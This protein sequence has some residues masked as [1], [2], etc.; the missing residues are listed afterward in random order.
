MPSSHISN[1]QEKK[2]Y[3][4][5]LKGEEGKTISITIN[6]V[7]K[8]FTINSI[9]PV[10]EGL[11]T[12]P[13]LELMLNNNP[14]DIAVIDIGGHNFNLRLF[15]NSGYSLDERG[16]S[17]EQVGINTL[18][19]NLHSELLSNLKDRDRKINRT[20]LR[21][22]VKNRDLY[23]DMELSDYNGTNKQF[24][25]EFVKNY[26]EEYIVDKLSAR[27]I[28]INTKGQIYLLTGGGALLLKPYF[29]E[30]Y[31][32]NLDFIKFSKTSKWD[33]CISFAL[34]TL[35]QKNT[36]RV[37]IFNI[38]SNDA[39][40]KLSKYDKDLNDNF[41]DFFKTIMTESTTM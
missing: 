41:S 2:A 7:F 32:D 29:E 15:S 10:S 21:N 35:F 13:R 22:F 3:E 5:L 16:V 18:L 25:D 39:P 1:P 40:N 9:I 26:I 34:N 24:I 36:N 23:P 14:Y 12:L 11:A 38:L 17:E 37:E 19:N 28:K 20:D 6:G 27:S 30:M 8:H 33:N 4:E 31:P